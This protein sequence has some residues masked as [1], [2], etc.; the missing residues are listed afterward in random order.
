MY[1]WVE[2]LPIQGTEEGRDPVFVV[3]LYGS[4]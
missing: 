1:T 3:G 2:L 4:L